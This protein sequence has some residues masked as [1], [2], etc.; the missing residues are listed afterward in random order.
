MASE[1]CV[2]QGEQES[3]VQFM[4][5]EHAA[6]LKALHQEIHKLQS[7]CTDLTFQ[8]TMSGVN[9]EEGGDA[10]SRLA[11]LQEQLQS[12]RGRTCALQSQVAEQGQRVQ[13]LTQ[14]LRAARKRRLDQAREAERTLSGLTAEAEAKAHNMALL[15]G[16]LHRLKL[17]QLPTTTTS[18]TLAAAVPS[19]EEGEGSVPGVKAAAAPQRSHNTHPHHHLPA[20]PPRDLLTSSAR[21]RRQRVVSGSTPVVGRGAVRP[22]SGAIAAI[23]QV[24]DTNTKTTTM[25]PDIAPFLQRDGA[26]AATEIGGVAGVAA[27]E[28]KVRK[29]AAPLPPIAGSRSRSVV[30]GPVAGERELHRVVISKGGH[31]QL[32]RASVPE[33]ATLAV[34]QI[35]DVG[36]GKKLPQSHGCH[37]P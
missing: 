32:T 35:S 34:D 30:R 16:Q 6:T 1:P 24:A 15:T 2:Q 21:M 14:E 11:E 10:D 5:Q 13:Q 31:P 36:W 22:V 18:T 23:Q 9:V 19:T 12:S 29:P 4:Q 17:H 3:S 27:L 20:P 26:A 25:P 8:L 33:V 7:K 37:N 28:V